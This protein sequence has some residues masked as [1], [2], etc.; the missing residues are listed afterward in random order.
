MKKAWP[1]LFYFLF[2]AAASGV[3]PYAA[4]YYQSIGLSGAQIGLLL[5]LSPLITLVGAPFFTGIADATHRHKLV[6]SLA[7]VA[8]IAWALMVPLTRS[9]PPLLLLISFYAL[10]ASPIS[11]LADSATMSMLG[12]ERAKYGRIRLGGTIGWG[13]MAY[14][15][16]LLVERNGLVWIFWIFAVGMMFTL[17][18]A[19]GLSFGQTQ[20]QINFWRG[21]NKLLANPRWVVFLGLALV[22]GVGMA[23]INS[24][25]FVYMAELG[26]SKSLMGLSIT[27]STLSELPALYFGNRLLKRFNAWGLLVLGTA[28]IAARLLLYAAFNVPVAILM[29]QVI[30][31]LTYPII[32]VA[33]VSYA[34]ANAPEGLNATAQG[35]FGAAIFGLGSGLGSFLGGLLIDHFAG[36]GM[37]FILGI[38]VLL[39]LLVFALIQRSLPNTAFALQPSNPHGD[40]IPPS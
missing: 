17:L 22:A 1:F 35:I 21:L 40:V 25:Q 11:S 2:Y 27:L 7:L 10:F 5:G 39:G 12:E 31:G 33:G 34:H 37:Y 9:F 20:P 18:V 8:I 3:F 13:V 16:S 4:L 32:W 6:I 19:Q 38:F 26:A 15:S 24:Y 23:S 14:F 36:R 28:V 29:I 30:H